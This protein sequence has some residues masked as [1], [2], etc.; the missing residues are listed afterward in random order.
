MSEFE[1][2]KSKIN[3]RDIKSSFIKKKIFSFLYE[4]KKLKMIEYNK[5]L[6]KVCLISIEDYKKKKVEYIKHW[7]KMEKG[8]NI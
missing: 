8:K 2:N 3:Y 1:D 7:K 5:E 4:K 6:Q